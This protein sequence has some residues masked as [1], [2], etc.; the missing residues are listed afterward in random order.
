MNDKN[1]KFRAHES[2]HKEDLLERYEL[3]QNIAEEL[4]DPEK[5]EEDIDLK[6]DI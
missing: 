6:Q 5:L 4:W 1:L 2:F 3:Y